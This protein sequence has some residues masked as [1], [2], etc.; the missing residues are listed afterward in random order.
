MYCTPGMQAIVVAHIVRVRSVGANPVLVQML[1]SDLYHGSH[2]LA[3]DILDA[4]RLPEERPI[5]ISA[6]RWISFFC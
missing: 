3:R 5:S 2:S 4:S 1:L 6:S